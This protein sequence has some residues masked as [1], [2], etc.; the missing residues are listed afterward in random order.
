MGKVVKPK[1]YDGLIDSLKK[2][3][4]EAGVEYFKKNI[5]TTKKEILEYA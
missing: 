4:V 3:A 2:K 5:E 1:I